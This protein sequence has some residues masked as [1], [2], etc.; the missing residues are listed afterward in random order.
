MDYVDALRGAACLWVLI[1][2]LLGSYIVG[3]GLARLP[4]RLLVKGATV[5]WLGVNL[6]LVLSGFCLYYPLVRRTRPDAVRLDWKTFARR[7][8]WRILPPYYAAMGVFYLFALRHSY[9]DKVPLKSDYQGWGNV[10]AH[11]FMLHNLHPSTIFAIN[12]VFW[13]LALESQL[14]VVFPLLVA[15]TAKRG[16]K[17]LLS[18]TLAVSLSWEFAVFL[19]FGLG[20][21]WSETQAVWYHALPGRVFEFAAGMVAAA[22]VASP[23]PQVGRYALR[24]GAALLIP[25]SFYAL[26]VYR[27]GPLLDQMWGVIFCCLILVLH[28]MPHDYFQKHLVTRALTWLGTIS[29]SLYLVH[30]LVLQRVAL[31]QHNDALLVL[32]SVGVVAVS[33]GVAALFFWCFERPFIGPRKSRESEIFQVVSLSP[34]S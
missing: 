29:Y 25:A 1:H 7:R 10:L 34:S 14:Y 16:L 27:A 5:G 8:A 6:F 20:R 26:F 28:E 2:H 12:G 18:T 17:A 30:N 9:F 33:I 24:L 13:S 32:K 21:G 15:L 11:L 23:R 22:L 4:L 3:P 19:H 31:P